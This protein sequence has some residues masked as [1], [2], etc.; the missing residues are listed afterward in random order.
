MDK[1]ELLSR[2]RAQKQH[3]EQELTQWITHIENI[4]ASIEIVEGREAS[5]PNFP[6]QN[7]FEGVPIRRIDSETYLTIARLLVNNKN[8]VRTPGVREQ[9]LIRELNIRAG[10][11]ER[12]INR[13]DNSAEQIIAGRNPNISNHLQRIQDDRDRLRIELEFHRDIIEALQTEPKRLTREEIE[14]EKYRAK[15]WHKR[16]YQGPKK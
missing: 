6:P 16:R 9:P 7:P 5:R 13:L 1:E 8:N 15:E 14:E 2:L 12:L 4:K 11:I 3:L 10:E